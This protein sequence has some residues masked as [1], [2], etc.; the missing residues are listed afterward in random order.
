MVF[1]S[2]SV[3]PKVSSNCICNRIYF[4]I[5]QSPVKC[6]LCNSQVAR[7]TAKARLL[8]VFKHFRTYFKQQYHY[9]H[10]I[11]F[12]GLL[13]SEHRIRQSGQPLAVHSELPT[14]VSQFLKTAGNGV[15]FHISCQ[16]VLKK[17]F[18]NPAQFVAFQKK[19]K[20]SCLYVIDCF[21]SCARAFS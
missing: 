9:H 13:P 19:L 12:H 21:M 14:V 3:K 17:C 10:D 20:S 1:T 4:E 8:F 5:V 2:S 18:I 15:F 7:Q 6:F 16:Q 11:H